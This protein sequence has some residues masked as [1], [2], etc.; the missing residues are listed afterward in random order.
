MTPEYRLSLLYNP[1]D[2]FWHLVVIAV[3][4]GMVFSVVFFASLELL[5]WIRRPRLGRGHR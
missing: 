5:G 2:P 1:S 4:C 3:L